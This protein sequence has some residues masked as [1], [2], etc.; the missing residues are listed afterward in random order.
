MQIDTFSF[1]GLDCQAIN[2]LNESADQCLFARSRDDCFDEE[3]WIHYPLLF[4]CGTGAVS[5]LFPLLVSSAL[6]LLYFMGLGMTAEDFMCPSL[7]S[8]SK[9]LRLSENIA[10]SKCAS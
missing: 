6:L 9:S 4:Y 1:E 8:I 5:K 3:G 7:E 2:S 10:V